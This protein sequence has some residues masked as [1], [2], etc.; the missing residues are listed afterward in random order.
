VK[1]GDRVE[2]NGRTGVVV[3]LQPGEMVDVRLDGNDF[4]QRANQARLARMNGAYGFWPLEAATAGAAAMLGLEESMVAEAKIG[5]GIGPGIYHELPDETTEA[6][7]DTL[8]AYDQALYFVALASRRAR[9]EEETSAATY[10]MSVL[11]DLEAGRAD[12]EE[13]VH[14]LCRYVGVGCPKGGQAAV[15]AEAINAV[16]TSGLN[17]DDTTQ[18]TRILRRN[19]LNAQLRQA[20]PIVAAVG[21]AGLVGYALYRRRQQ[22]P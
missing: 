1:P 3:G 21:I 6:P 11:E 15:L 8:E 22:V 19:R 13:D 7:K 4:V 5:S 12:A 16:E 18:I 9:Q 14:F 17:I 20:A 10:L 2:L